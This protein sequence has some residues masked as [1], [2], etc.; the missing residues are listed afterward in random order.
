[1]AFLFHP[2]HPPPHFPLHHLCAGIRL[3]A[4]AG[5]ELAAAARRLL[6]QLVVCFPFGAAPA[7]QQL[8]EHSQ[9][10]QRHHGEDEEQQD[11]EAGH[12]PAVV[13]GVDLLDLQGDPGDERGVRVPREV[14]RVYGAGAVGHGSWSERETDGL[15]GSGWVFFRWQQQGAEV[16]KYL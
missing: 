9:R 15:F 14:T 16:I 11:D 4:H 6:L 2:L 1:M 12:V 8:V 5:H 3:L 13:E 10:G 7:V